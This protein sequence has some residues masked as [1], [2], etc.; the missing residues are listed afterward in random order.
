MVEFQ[1]GVD[2]FP[3]LVDIHGFGDEIEGPG[4]Q[5]TDGGFGTAMGGND[6]DRNM[7]IITL[8]FLHQFDAVAVR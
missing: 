4:F 7:G 8:D 2:H 6:R 5:G 3:Q 1:G